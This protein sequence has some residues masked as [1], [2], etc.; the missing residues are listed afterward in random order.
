MGGVDEFLMIY[1]LQNYRIYYRLFKVCELT[2]NP[3]KGKEIG[4]FS[5]S[6]GIKNSFLNSQ[7]TSAGKRLNVML[8][9]RSK[10]FVE[11]VL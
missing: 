4:H 6:H 11:K 8:K 10:A 3:C 5:I 1:M 2:V 9:K 7:R